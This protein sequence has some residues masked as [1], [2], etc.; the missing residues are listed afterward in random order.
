M[1]SKRGLDYLAGGLLVA[2]VATIV[3]SIATIPISADTFREDPSGVLADIVEDRNLFIISQAFDLANNF[4]IIPMAAVLYLVFR[5]HDRTLA[6]I[7][8]FG[9]LAGGVL[10]MTVDMVTISLITLAQDYDGATGAQ[11]DSLLS[12]SR[13]IGLMIDVANMMGA[14]GMAMGALSYGLLVLT[15]NALPRW[16]GAFGIAGGIVIP[17]GWLLFV[18]T[19]LADIMYIGLMIALFFFLISGVWLIWRGA[20]EPRAA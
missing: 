2:M 6:L 16:M 11:A 10:F 18:D 14:V 3:A 1:F 7:G 4:I 19:D 12:A 15:T 17:F 13:A 5:S 20:S 9:I 8:S